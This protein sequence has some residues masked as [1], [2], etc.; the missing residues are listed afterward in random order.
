MRQIGFIAIGRNE[1][2]RLHRCIESAR[3]VSDLVIYV[4]SASTDGSVQWCRQRGVDVVELDATAPLSAARARNAGFQRLRKVWPNADL[5]HFLDG[6]CELVDDWP[7]VAAVALA[8]RPEAA[9]VCGR[10]RERHP[11]VSIYN[12]LCD[13]EFDRPAGEVRSC[14]GVF[15]IR[16]AAFEQVGGFNPAVVAGEE[17]E[18][19]LRLRREGWKILRLADDMV[20]H[21]AAMTRF[22]QW[23]RR[24]VRGGHAY[25]QAMS[26]HGL[27][28]DWFGVH[29]SM[30]IWFW[31]LGVPLLVA[32][33][34][35]PTR[36]WSGLLIL[37]YPLQAWR[38][39]SQR[40]RQHGPGSYAW[41]HA[42]FCMLA[43][44]AEFVG[45]VRFWSAR[46]AHRRPRIIEY[47][48]VGQATGQPRTVQ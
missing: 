46:L 36:G 33:T 8:A 42:W 19:C 47:K 6:D 48:S 10:V 1:G 43:K 44:W 17:P 27:A 2:E 3:R 9:V 29:E 16:A 40:R 45:Q 41:T 5:V 26:M 4:D 31:A 38:I 18:M 21:D 12:R 13:L 14:G 34:A 37:I 20:R 23:W 32:A 11:E 39:A 25:A 30:R 24:A 35:W 22:G 7:T 15:L 28:P